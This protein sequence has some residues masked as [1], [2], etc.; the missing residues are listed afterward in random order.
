MTNS[1]LTHARIAT[2]LNDI[3]A[4]TIYFAEPM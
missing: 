4:Q 3:L 1:E 2:V